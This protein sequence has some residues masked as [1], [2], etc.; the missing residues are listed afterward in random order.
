MEVQTDAPVEL[1]A[2]A[3]GRQGN[4]RTRL[5]KELPAELKQW[6]TK[7]SRIHA[8]ICYV[9][10]LFGNPSRA[11][12]T[13][14]AGE[15]YEAR[16]ARGDRTLLFDCLSFCGDEIDR[17]RNEVQAS[18]D[19]APPTSAVPGSAEKVAVMLARAE[20]GES[21]FIKGDAPIPLE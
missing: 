18:M 1:V 5:D 8:H 11:G 20:R 4:R 9:V 14:N 16:A 2:D 13:S 19:S 15:T 6:L 10:R 21:I 3:K 7:A 12:G 17:L